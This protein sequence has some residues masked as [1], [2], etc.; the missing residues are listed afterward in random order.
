MNEHVLPYE[1]FT[2]S[3]AVTGCR[4]LLLP[5]DIPPTQTPYI[6]PDAL[7]HLLPG[8]QSVSK[9]HANALVDKPQAMTT[10]QALKKMRDFILISFE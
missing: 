1:R 8:W 10:A 5:G 2:S 4:S 3:G 9:E 6:E 7:R